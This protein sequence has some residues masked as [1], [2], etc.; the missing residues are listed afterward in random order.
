MVDL[1]NHRCSYSSTKKRPV[2]YTNAYLPK[3]LD[4]LYHIYFRE[5]ILIFLLLNTGE[6][7]IYMNISRQI[8]TRM[9][10]HFIITFS[11]SDFPLFTL[12]EITQT[13]N[14]ASV[15]VRSI[16]K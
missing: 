7:H 3:I 9:V 12:Y 5:Q 1:Y 13:I 11:C 15:Y 10:E 6:Q 8:G 2:I 16:H 14:P 4:L